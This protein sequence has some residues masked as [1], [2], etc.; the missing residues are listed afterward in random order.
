MATT[1][2]PRYRFGRFEAYPGSGEL[3]KDGR[4][5]RVQEKPF[6]LLLTLLERPGEVVRQEEL[7]ERL[8]PG[9]IHVDFAHGLGNAIQKLREALGDT[10]EHPTFVETIPRRG[11]RFLAPVEWVTEQTETAIPE[12]PTRSRAARLAW[13]AASG[14]VLAAAGWQLVR[15]SRVASSAENGP[16]R[17]AYVRARHLFSLKTPEGIQKSVVYYR[18]A[19]TQ[20][21]RMARAWAGLAHAYHFLGAMGILSKEEAYQ[22]ASESAR[23]ALGIDVDLAEAHAV[24]AETTYRF[25]SP[26]AEGVETGFRRAL[27]LAPNS[28][29]VRQWYGNYLADT[30]RLAEGI[31]QMERARELEPLSSH[32]GIDMAY[33]YYEAGRREEA[34]RQLEQT[35]ELNP[36]FPKVYSLAGYMHRKEKH[37]DAAAA[38]FRR[39]VA[40]A[41][42]TPKF[43]IALA[44]NCMDAGRWSEAEQSL[45]ELKR[46]E[47]R[48]SV[49]AAALLRL[50]EE[51]RL[52]RVR[53]L[54]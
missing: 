20:E 28:A 26:S 12:A 44:E 17:E 47:G 9:G 54:P 18:E 6:Q 7:R 22:R 48:R 40:L 11:Y 31:A 50:E 30:A 19:I 52:R 36:N 16:G 51:L 4:R 15:S 1:G 41:P 29:E 45:R 25:V 34:M 38:D 21:P 14:L 43:L 49:P 35:R 27:E 5:V 10:V 32:I 23:A 37:Y 8:W 13:L 2:E 33:L 42:E 53:Q 46:L 39:A 3:R 24:L